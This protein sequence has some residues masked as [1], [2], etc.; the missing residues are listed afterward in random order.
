MNLRGN[1]IALFQPRTQ[2]GQSATL[3]AKGKIIC[4]DAMLPF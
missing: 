2:I 3:T 1:S 4:I